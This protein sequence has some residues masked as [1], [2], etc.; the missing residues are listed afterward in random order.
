[1]LNPENGGEDPRVL[2]LD[3]P[4]AVVEGKRTL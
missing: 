1:L 3:E 2:T 4:K